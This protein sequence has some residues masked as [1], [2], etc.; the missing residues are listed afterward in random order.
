MDKVIKIFAVLAVLI[1]LAMPASARY[2]IIRNQYVVR[3]SG[4]NSIQV[5][6]SNQ[7]RTALYLAD[8]DNAKVAARDVV[9]LAWENKMKER[10]SL[11]DVQDEIN[12][13]AVMYLLGERAHSLPVDIGVSEVNRVWIADG[14][15]KLAKEGGKTFIK[16]M[17]TQ[18]VY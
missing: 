14:S 18:P 8:Y 16:T 3:V 11:G 10:R 15:W 5:D 17:T 2:T 1:L 9:T 4:Q 13:H 6:G 7:A 12:T